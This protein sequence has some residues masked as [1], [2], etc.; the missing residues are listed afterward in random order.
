MMRARILD[1][2][3]PNERAVMMIDL[4]IPRTDP[5]PWS[6]RR[7][8]GGFCGRA[9]VVAPATW[10]NGDARCA[11]RRPVLIVFDPR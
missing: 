6:R 10:R 3:F 11:R 7:H 1:V 8:G 5:V 9:P 4:Q 2:T